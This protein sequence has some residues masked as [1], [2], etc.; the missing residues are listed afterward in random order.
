MM[1]TTCPKC[2][3][4]FGGPKTQEA[5]EDIGQGSRCQDPRDVGLVRFQSKIWYK[6]SPEGTASVRDRAT[7]SKTGITWRNDFNGSQGR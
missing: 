7:P 4:R 6:P 2:G 5:H 1:I 3:D